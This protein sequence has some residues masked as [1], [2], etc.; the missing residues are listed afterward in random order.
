MN[1]LTV[2]KACLRLFYAL[3]RGERDERRRRARSMHEERMSR[4]RHQRS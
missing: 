3:W 2:L 1:A 4:R